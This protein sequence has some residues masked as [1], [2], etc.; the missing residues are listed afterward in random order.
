MLSFNN[1]LGRAEGPFE[2]CQKS[3]MRLGSVQFYCTPDVWHYDTGYEYGRLI[4]NYLK[5]FKL[6]KYFGEL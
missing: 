1:D 6:I 5:M 4:L 2:S 3:L